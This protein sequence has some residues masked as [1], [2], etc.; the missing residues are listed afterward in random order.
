[1]VL[2]PPRAL[3]LPASGQG[4][5]TLLFPSEDALRGDLQLPA[6]RKK[7]PETTFLQHGLLMAFLSPPHGPQSMHARGQLLL[8][9]GTIGASRPRS[10]P[11]TSP[12]GLENPSHGEESF[13]WSRRAA[14]HAEAPVKVK[15]N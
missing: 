11:A 13:K 12:R 3:A 6:R 5:K 10:F 14:Y 8:E 9:K 1:M 7:P 4:A 2:S 15:I